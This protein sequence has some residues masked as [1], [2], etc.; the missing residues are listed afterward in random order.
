M[1][2]IKK[3]EQKETAKLDEPEIGEAKTGEPDAI[4]APKID[5]NKK[6]AAVN[7]S[8]LAHTAYSPSNHSPTFVKLITNI[9]IV[10]HVCLV[11][12]SGVI[13]I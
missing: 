8:V 7:M 2:P 6:T 4:E 11:M 5:E 3:D 13:C 9:N 1:L 10:P 12:T